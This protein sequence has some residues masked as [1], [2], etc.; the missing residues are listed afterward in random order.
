MGRFDLRVTTAAPREGDTPLDLLGSD[1]GVG[2]WGRRWPG[3]PRWV[4]LVGIAAASA[5]AGGLVAGAS[6]AST[7]DQAFPPC[8][9][10][11]APS[12]QPGVTLDKSW[13]TGGKG[14][15]PERA[16]DIVTHGLPYA[17]HRRAVHWVASSRSGYN[18]DTIVF[19]GEAVPM[20]V[21]FETDGSEGQDLV[22]VYFSEPLPDGTSTAG[23]RMQ[24]PIP[25]LALKPYQTAVGFTDDCARRIV[26]TR[27]TADTT[28]QLT[29][30][31]NPSAGSFRHNLVPTRIT[32][33][34]D[35]E[36]PPFDTATLHIEVSDTVRHGTIDMRIGA[37]RASPESTPS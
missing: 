26:V 30:S 14:M 28:W 21:E 34:T 12:L 29:V 7:S 27:P 18:R 37:E 3:P 2:G 20:A 4:G 36:R 23:L 8:P 6:G 16:A 1:A 11:P 9:K 35:K 31:D 33:T 17:G 19:G 32:L 10:A 13:L 15:A 24:A 22:S 25:W 5:L